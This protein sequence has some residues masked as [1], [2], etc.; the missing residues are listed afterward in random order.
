M[1]VLMIHLNLM[2]IVWHCASWQTLF[3]SSSE[4]ST[5]KSLDHGKLLSKDPLNCSTIFFGNLLIPCFAQ[6][7]KPESSLPGENQQFPH[8]GVKPDIVD[9]M[10]KYS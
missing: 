7:L 1:Y 4:S 10:L 2:L 9:T 5:S 8:I 6:D 3:H